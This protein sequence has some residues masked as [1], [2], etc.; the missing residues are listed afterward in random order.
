MGQPH[1]ESLSVPV[2]TPSGGGTLGERH[3]WIKRQN[4]IN[5]AYVVTRVTST[6][7]RNG[8]G[9]IER[10]FTLTVKPDRG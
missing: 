6:E 9:G 7:L 3:T 8:G 4:D 2:R 5:W 1:P 10:R